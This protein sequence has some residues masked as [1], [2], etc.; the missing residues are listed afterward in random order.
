MREALICPDCHRRV[1]REAGEEL[2]CLACGWQ[3]S[4]QRGPHTTYIAERDDHEPI[5][6]TP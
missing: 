2:V 1:R 5:S 3:E 6:T 4:P